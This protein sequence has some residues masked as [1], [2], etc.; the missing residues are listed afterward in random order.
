MMTPIIDNKYIAAQINLLA[1]LLELHNENP[2]KIKNYTYAAQLIKKYPDALVAL[3]EDALKNI[4]G[5]GSA[6]ASK[7]WELIQ[8]GKIAEL[9]NQLDKT[10]IGVV[11]ML[12]VKGLGAKKVATLWKE[13]GIETI[14]ELEYACTENRL[15]SFKGFGIKTQ[16]SILQNIAFIKSNT[17]YYLWADAT[18]IKNV[19]EKILQQFFPENTFTITGDYVHQLTTL[20]TLIWV[21]DCP[22][23]NIE[24]HFT[25]T[26]TEN[27]IAH[28]NDNTLTLSFPN[29]ITHQFRYTNRENIVKEAFLLSGDEE[30]IGTFT[31]K[32]TIQNVQNEEDI[33]KQHS[34]NYIPPA[35]RYGKKSIELAAQ[36]NLPDLI[37]T[38]DIKGVIH[39]HTTYSDGV[40]TVE[41]MANEAI[42]RGYEYIVISDHSQSAGYAGGLKL[43]NILQQHE[44]IN[45]LNQ[46][47]HPFKIY[48]SIESDILSDGALDYPS[49]VLAKFDLVIASVHS[50]LNMTQEKAM[51]R[52]LTAIRNPFTTIL[53]HPSGRLLLSREGYPL[54]YITLIDE[55]AKHNVAIEINAHP[56]RLDI[57]WQWIP[58]ALSKNV[59]LSVNPDAHSIAG[60]DVLQYGIAAA[61]K[62]YL[63]AANNLSS[64]NK[65][66]LEH[67][68]E[69]QTPKRLQ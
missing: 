41:E 13:M 50:N 69:K 8:T 36:N 33:F 26:E 63:T 10:P 14:G 3:E 43:E 9:E 17:G 66:E 54:D 59:L 16:E 52:I 61:Q 51:Q 65:I 31:G 45:Q 55:C 12:Q 4:K 15:I 37:Q 24:K 20:H 23:S 11:E 47:L 64:F 21:T 58:Y 22:L 32:Y 60:I 5:I 7:I 6:T 18:E 39:C 48:K 25:N 67:F 53:G 57:D 30:F 40:N 56:R 29:T 27:T 49:E 62:G 19:T 2:F 28:I 38:K 68:L 34:L 35:L 1:K 42:K 46:K 44:E